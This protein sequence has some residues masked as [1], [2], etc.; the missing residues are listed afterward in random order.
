MIDSYVG[1]WPVLEQEPFS[2]LRQ[3]LVQWIRSCMQSHDQDKMHA[4]SAAGCSCLPTP[5]QIALLYEPVASYIAASRLDEAAASMRCV[6]RV[7]LTAAATVDEEQHNADHEHEVRVAHRRE[8]QERWAAAYKALEEAA[9]ACA[10]EHLNG[11]RLR[12][13]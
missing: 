1:D 7:L 9:Q 6:R 12:L 8:T 3:P 2:E 5:A 10:Q 11:A 13:D 4:D